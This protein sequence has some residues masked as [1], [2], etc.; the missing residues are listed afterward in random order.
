M[1]FF[2]LSELHVKALAARRLSQIR[3]P[4][5][6][7]PEL[8]KNVPWYDGA[9]RDVWWWGKYFPVDDITHAQCSTHGERISIGYGT[10]EAEYEEWCEY[11][12][13]RRGDT[14]GVKEAWDYNLF[15]PI[16]PKSVI[17]KATHISSRKNWRSPITMPI[18]AVRYHLSIISVGAARVQDTIG[19]DAVECGVEV[20][21]CRSNG[22]P[23][24]QDY[25][26]KANRLY[27]RAV[28]SYA[29]FWNSR[30]GKKSGL[31]WGN[32]PW[33]WVYGVVPCKFP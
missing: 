18:W 8:V 27:D 15:G 25:S 11:A 31:A 28:D 13:C 26:K 14:V 2:Y 20:I 9:V 4:M 21:D 17:Y 22:S 10:K 1:K 6:P 32:N 23:I 29:S 16:E 12:P 3:V 30:Y 24:Y 33:C 5:N 19:K 7:Q